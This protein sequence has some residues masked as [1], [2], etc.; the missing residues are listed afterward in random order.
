LFC[1]TYELT[2]SFIGSSPHFNINSNFSKI[3][4][5]ILEFKDIWQECAIQLAP[6]NGTTSKQST[7]GRR[8]RF[9]GRPSSKALGTIVQSIEDKAIKRSKSANTSKLDVSLK[10]EN[11]E[12]RNRMIKSALDKQNFIIDDQRIKLKGQQKEIDELRKLKDQLDSG[13]AITNKVRK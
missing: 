13:R 6:E 4:H 9:K 12:P 3:F 7:P 2:R 5:Y 8:S 11:D 1:N 10:L